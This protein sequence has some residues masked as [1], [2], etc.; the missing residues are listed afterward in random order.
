MSML[1]LSL[2]PPAAYPNNNNAKYLLVVAIHGFSVRV[3]VSS[4]ADPMQHPK[5]SAVYQLLLAEAAHRLRK[6]EQLL[7]LRQQVVDYSEHRT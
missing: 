3:Y 2:Q 1:L 4:I 6:W 5:N 7:L